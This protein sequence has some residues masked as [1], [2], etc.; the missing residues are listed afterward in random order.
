MNAK[1]ERKKKGQNIEF[2]EWREKP[3]I[4]E[5]NDNNKNLKEKSL[6]MRISTYI[7]GQCEYI[8]SEKSAVLLAIVIVIVIAVVVVVVLFWRETL[9]LSE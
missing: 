5:W 9:L 3:G 8:K 6:S 1:K 7:V 4:T 2:I